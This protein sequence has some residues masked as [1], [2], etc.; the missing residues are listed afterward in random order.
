MNGLEKNNKNDEKW[1]EFDI[2]KDGVIDKEEVKTSLKNANG[3]AYNEVRL[4]KEEDIKLFSKRK[5]TLP[6]VY[7]KSKR[8]RTKID[9]VYNDLWMA[10]KEKYEL[11]DTKFE[12]W[13]E[14]IKQ[15]WLMN[16]IDGQNNGCTI[17]HY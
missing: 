7:A 12:W 13:L 5:N 16:L 1:N 8:I 3:K 14:K 15:V 2:N 4:S 10:T 11:D 17:D 9:K 6:N